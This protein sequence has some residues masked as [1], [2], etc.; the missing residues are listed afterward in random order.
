MLLT[1]PADAQHRSRI[2]ESEI[3]SNSKV[4]EAPTGDD[5]FVAEPIDAEAEAALTIELVSS[6]V[7]GD[8][9]FDLYRN[10]E[11]SCGQSGFHTFIV[12]STETTPD[13]TSRPL[14]IRLLGG[15]T[16]WFDPDGTYVFGGIGRIEE[17]RDE[18]L[19]AFDE[20]G[21]M[22]MIDSEPADFRI[23][24]PGMCDHDNYF[25]TGKLDTN[26]PFGLDPNGNERRVDGLSAIRDAVDFTMQSYATD[27]KFIQGTSSGSV[28]A[29]NYAIQYAGRAVAP[30]AIIL[31]TGTF[32]PYFAQITDEGCTEFGSRNIRDAASRLSWTMTNNG[33]IIESPHMPH[34]AVESGLLDIPIYEIWSRNE[35]SICGERIVTITLEDGS[36]VTEESQFLAHFRLMDAIGTHNPGGNSV[37]RVVCADRP[38]GLDPKAPTFRRCGLHGITKFSASSVGGDMDRAGEDFNQAIL[39]WVVSFLP[40]TPAPPPGA[41]NSSGSSAIDPMSAL[42]MLLLA[43]VAG[44]SFRRGA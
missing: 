40:A 39:D 36:Q 35:P 23:L 12:A 13:T 34:V 7:E 37:S 1:A 20:D 21:L 41:N 3:V 25:G 32:S 18:L 38:A 4:G 2:L 15:G 43:A 33:S 8:K 22:A 11:R 10:L 14:W 29:A 19:R 28:G 44:L 5:E 16:G 26:N 30:N 17:W 6:F 9:R 27:Q 42:L 24:I 31:D